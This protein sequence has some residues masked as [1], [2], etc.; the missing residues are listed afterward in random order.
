MGQGRKAE[1]RKKRDVKRRRIMSKEQRYKH[2]HQNEIRE[3]ND[4]IETF[5]RDHSISDNIAKV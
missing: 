4:T 1:K 5:R 2:L 3:V